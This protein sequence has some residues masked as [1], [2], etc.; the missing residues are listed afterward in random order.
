MVVEVL[1]QIYAR[2]QEI[3]NGEV[4]KNKV[5]PDGSLLIE[6]VDP[7]LPLDQTE[8]SLE[9]IIVSLC[10]NFG[11][12]V[13]QAAGLLTQDNKYLNHVVVKGMKGKYDQVLTWYQDLHAH[14]KHILTLLTKEDP[15]AGAEL[16]LGAFKPGFF[17]KSVE[18]VQWCSRVFSKLGVEF[19][20]NDI[21]QIG[22]D[23]FVAKDGG[24]SACISAL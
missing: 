1:E 2:E 24:I 17:S 6:A 5:A 23:W 11:L 7:N 3:S 18:V 15:V 22:W 10:K 19:V 8:I 9:F 20:D 4:V 21:V 16:F 14:S 13:K 12:K